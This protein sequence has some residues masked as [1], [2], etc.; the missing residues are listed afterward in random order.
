[1]A[2]YMTDF[3]NEQNSPRSSR[4]MRRDRIDRP[5]V[6]ASKASDEA[7]LLTGCIKKCAVQ[8]RATS[9]R[10][11]HSLIFKRMQIKRIADN[12]H[13]LFF[14][15]TNWNKEPDEKKLHRRE[16]SSN[17]KK[18]NFIQ[19]QSV[20]ASAFIRGLYIGFI[21]LLMISYCDV[22]KKCSLLD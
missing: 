9:D 8:G 5:N 21:N 14:K 20:S 7:F 13:A 1:M 15:L 6:M 4:V 18:K 11:P 2:N 12:V 3:G 17:K 19:T 22:L 16:S 10:I